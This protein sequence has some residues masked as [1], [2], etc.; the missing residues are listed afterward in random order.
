MG[1]EHIIPE[2]VQQLMRLSKNL[3]IGRILLPIQGSGTETRAFCNIRDGVVGLELAGQK[4]GD[5]SLFNIGND[6][7]IQIATVIEKTAQ[8]LGLEVQILPGEIRPGSPP[9]RC[10]DIRH[11]RTMG[12]EPQVG[13][14]EGLKETVLWYRDHFSFETQA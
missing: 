6:Q 14:D 3:K 2:T 4:G 10:P 11:L 9:R 8:I 5:G 12:Y 1:F 13:F 7:E